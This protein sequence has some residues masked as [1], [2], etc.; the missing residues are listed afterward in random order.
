MNASHELSAGCLWPR[1]TPMYCGELV[2]LLVLEVKAMLHHFAPVVHWEPG[3][4]VD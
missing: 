4:A 1:L 3:V 2:A